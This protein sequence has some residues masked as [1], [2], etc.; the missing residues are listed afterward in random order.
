VPERRLLEATD[1]FSGLPPDV[2]DELRAHATVRKLKRNEVLFE[3]GDEADALFVVE[4]GRIAI[5]TQSGDGRESVV[6]VLERGALFGEMPLFDGDTRSTDARA[7]NNSTVVELAYEPVFD[8]LRTRPQLLWGVVRLLSQRLRATNEALADAVFL[9]V[10][11]RTA[12]HLLEL[13]GDD[14]NFTLPVTQEELAAMV[15]ASRE[16]VNKALSLFMRL[17]WLDLEGRNHYRI[18]DRTSLEDRSSL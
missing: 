14:D 12:K 3:Q 1:L 4:S 18:L 8:V 6:A 9:D 13:A 16:R 17:G 7:L 2:L 10:P 15:G 11:A 5:A